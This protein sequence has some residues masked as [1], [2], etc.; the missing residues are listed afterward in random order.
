[1]SGRLA[2]VI[3]TFVSDGWVEG[4]RQRKVAAVNLFNFS[5]IESI[6]S[7]SLD[8]HALGQTAATHLRAQGARRF[9]FYG[10]DG[11]YYTRLRYQ[12]FFES[13]PEP[14][15]VLRPGP[16]L[17]DQIATL[18]ADSGLLGVFCATDAL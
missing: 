15:T 11:V 3:G 18:K 7:V 6:P 5:K 2:G 16:P 12:G 8:D 1:A 17:R 9:A 14:C 10:A 4:L 13:L